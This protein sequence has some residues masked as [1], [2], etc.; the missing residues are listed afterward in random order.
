[1]KKLTLDPEM[2]AVESFAPA[3]VADGA[4]GT[5]RG[6]SYVSADTNCHT[7]PDGYENSCGH[8]CINKCRATVLPVCGP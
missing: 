3:G 6:H 7:D 4:P 8:S 2:L 5:V 1:M